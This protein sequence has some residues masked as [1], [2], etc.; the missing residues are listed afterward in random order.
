MIV[1][2]DRIGGSIELNQTNEAIPT[3][4]LAYLFP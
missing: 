2:I 1:E 4:Y 3:A